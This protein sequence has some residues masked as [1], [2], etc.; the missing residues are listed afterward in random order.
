MKKPTSIHAIIFKKCRLRD[1]INNLKKFYKN[2]VMKYT[3]M[4]GIIVDLFGTY[5]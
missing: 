5:A 3:A 4:V 1:R 2:I